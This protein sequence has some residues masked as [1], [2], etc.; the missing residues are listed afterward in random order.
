MDI[1]NLV[2]SA[3]IGIIVYLVAQLLGVPH[4]VAV[5]V[6]LLVFLV[7]AFGGGARLVR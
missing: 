3:I 6:G 4:L 1:I 2:I 7:I 5:L